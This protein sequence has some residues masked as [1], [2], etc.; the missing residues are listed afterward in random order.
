MALNANHTTLGSKLEEWLFEIFVFVVHDEADVHQRTV[1]SVHRSTE[2]T[3]AVYFVVNHLCA[4]MGPAV[5]LLYTSL[6]LA[7]A[8]GLKQRVDGDNGWCVEHTTLLHMCAVVNHG[9]Q[10][11][12]SFTQHVVLDDDDRHTRHGHV[13]LCTGINGRV[14]GDIDRPAHDV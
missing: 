7:P 1:T 4:F 3:V 12:W 13:L 8:H 14:L 10:F 9:R 11:S 2:E 6:S 5:H